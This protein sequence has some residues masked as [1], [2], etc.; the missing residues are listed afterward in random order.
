MLNRLKS[1]FNSIFSKNGTES[2]SL[3]PKED[4]FDSIFKARNSI[5]S[6]FNKLGSDFE[7]EPPVSVEPLALP[8]K[9]PRAPRSKPSAPVKKSAAAKPTPT[10]T[11]ASKSAAKKTSTTAKTAAAPKTAASKKPVA[12][13]P[14]AKKP[15]AKK[16][17][18]S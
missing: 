17:S 8:V 14:V 9:K 5:A 13:K 16:P 10:K 6:H 4:P 15:A 2:P 7:S 3:N 18:A 11:P 12:T 1:A